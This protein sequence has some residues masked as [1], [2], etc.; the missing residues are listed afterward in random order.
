MLICDNCKS[1]LK[2]ISASTCPN[3]GAYFIYPEHSYKKFK[4]ILIGCIIFLLVIPTTYY[5]LE[6]ILFSNPNIFHTILY[7]FMTVSTIVLSIFL[8]RTIRRHNILT[9]NPQY[10][11]AHKDIKPIEE[12]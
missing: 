6:Y 5:Y 4:K 9:K 2:K 3:C 8:I 11:T 7:L 12:K 1:R 10:Q